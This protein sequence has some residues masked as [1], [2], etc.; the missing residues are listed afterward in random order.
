[1]MSVQTIS[2]G[3]APG[4]KFYPDDRKKSIL[5]S[6]LLIVFGVAGLAGSW[7]LVQAQQNAF[8]RC[9]ANNP[10]TPFQGSLIASCDRFV[11]DAMPLAVGSLG[12]LG[13]I[14][15][16]GLLLQRALRSGL[17]MSPEGVECEF[18][19]YSYGTTWDNVSG[20]A[21]RPFGAKD[22]YFECLTLR[23]P[24]V[25]SRRLLTLHP[26]AEFLRL[27]PLG[28]F[29]ATWRDG[30]IGEEIKRYAPHLLA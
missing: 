18:E 3:G 14:L 23:K 29:A 26:P 24:A 30:E 17:S 20:I 21:A 6:T 16:G 7:L 4:R 27:I 10:T 22:I 19:F 15:G 12:S 11:P 9:L 2:E 13:M 25:E 8:Q 1:M 5:L 28:L